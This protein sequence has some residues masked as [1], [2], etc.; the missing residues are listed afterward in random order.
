MGSTQRNVTGKE[1]GSSSGYLFVGI[2]LEEGEQQ[3]EAL[4]RGHHAVALLQALTSSLLP[5]IIHSHIHWLA[6]E[7]QPCQVLYLQAM[8]DEALDPG[9][10]GGRTCDTPCYCLT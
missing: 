1:A 6:L 9:L 8:P 2:A 5:L 4:L 10:F 3:Q 7:G